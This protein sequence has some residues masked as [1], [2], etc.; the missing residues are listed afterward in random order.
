MLAHK[1]STKTQSLP[2]QTSSRKLLPQLTG[3]L[4]STYS[5]CGLRNHQQKLSLCRLRHLRGNCFHGSHV[6]STAHTAPVGSEIINENSVTAD[7]EIFEETASTAHTWSR[8]RIQLLWAQ[9]SSTKTQSLP[10][11]KSS[12]KLLPRLTNSSCWL[13][14]HQRKLILCG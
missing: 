13:R 9:K 3:G 2:T 1:S 11:Q 10:T 8:Q 5:S 12:R 4:D 14:N 6:E 7:S